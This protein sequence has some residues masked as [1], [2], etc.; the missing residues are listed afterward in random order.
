MI[1]I[2]YRH[3]DQQIVREFAIKLSEAYGQEN[4]FY[5]EWSIQPGDGIIDAMSAGLD[6]CRFFFFFVTKSSLASGM[7]RLEWQNALCKS[8]NNED[9]KFIPVRLAP[10]EFPSILRQT[11]YI[12]AYSQGLEVALRQMYDVIN[13]QSTF[14]KADSE[15]H[16]LTAAINWESDSACSIKISATTFMEPTS[17]YW[18][19]YRNDPADIDYTVESDALIEVAKGKYLL[20]YDGMSLSYIKFFVQRATT[21]HF[22]FRVKLTTKNNVKLDIAEVC[23]DSGNSTLMFLPLTQVQTTTFS[24]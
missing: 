7:V 14:R 22:P 20:R 13:G 18:I 19:L 24:H 4:V 3:D 1:F 10:C 12:D 21:P 8:A 6:R 9:I 17:R 16:N 2:S 15:F 5:D 23:H 11:L